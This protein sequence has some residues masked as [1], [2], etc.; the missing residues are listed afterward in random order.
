LKP[1]FCLAFLCEL[2]P[3]NEDDL[4]FLADKLGNLLYINLYFLN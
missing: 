2:N 3:L 1:L 4:S